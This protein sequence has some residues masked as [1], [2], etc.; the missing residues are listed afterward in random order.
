M[1]EIKS[2]SNGEMKPRVPNV[3]LEITRSLSANPW[4]GWEICK[5]CDILEQIQVVFTVM[6]SS[7]VNIMHV[8]RIQDGLNALVKYIEGNE[9]I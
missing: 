3:A 9:L 8:Q 2:A 5:I 4:M 6:F 7:K 1:L